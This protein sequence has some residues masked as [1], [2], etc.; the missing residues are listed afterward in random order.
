MLNLQAIFP[1]GFNSRL[2]Y[3]FIKEGV[4]VLVRSNFSE[5]PRISTRNFRISL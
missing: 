4:L 2:D 1:D 5:L 3:D